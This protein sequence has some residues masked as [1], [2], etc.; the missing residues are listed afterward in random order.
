M[1]DYLLGLCQRG[2]ARGTFKTSH[3]GL[4]FFYHHTL[5][6]AW[7]LF[8]ETYTPRSADDN[9]GR[10]GM[11][12]TC[13]LLCISTFIWMAETAASQGSASRCGRDARRNRR[14]ET[15]D[16]V[17]DSEIMARIAYWDR[18]WPGYRWQEIALS[19]AQA[20]PRLSLWHT[21]AIASIAIHDLTVATWHAKH[22]Y[23]R[24]RPS[25]VDPAIEPAVLVPCSRSRS[26]LPEHSPL[27]VLLGGH[28]RSK[29]LRPLSSFGAGRTEWRWHCCGGARRARRRCDGTGT[30]QRG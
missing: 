1:R 11:R 25:E 13:A 29:H 5:G 27:I 14:S 20:D 15:A 24:P 16:G 19:E 30:R 26:D 28:L 18:G 7:G 21:M 9:V 22:Q 4:R 6:Q 17:A 2:V 12:I 10:R 3:Y 23:S 8:G